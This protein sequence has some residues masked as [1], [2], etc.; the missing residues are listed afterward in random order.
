M[1]RSGRNGAVV[2]AARAARAGGRIAALVGLL[3]AG[4]LLG[5][6]RAGAAERGAQQGAGPA[7]ESPYA[8]YAREH[9]RTAEKKPVRVRP[10]S[11]TVHGARGGARVARH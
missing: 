8:R 3:V 2:A 1:K 9:A 7:K 5:Q 4:L 11:S 10:S 6:A